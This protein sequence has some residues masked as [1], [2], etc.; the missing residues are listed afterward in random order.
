[1]CLLPPIARL[2]ARANAAA[3]WRAKRLHYSHLCH[4]KEAERI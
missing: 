2:N 1:M 3:Q 4:A